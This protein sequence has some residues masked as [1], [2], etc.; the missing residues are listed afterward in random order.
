MRTA[1]PRRDRALPG[2]ADLLETG[3]TLVGHRLDKR[4]VVRTADGYAKVVRPSRA[5]G[6][7]SRHTR[8]AAALA[9]VPGAPHV[10]EL[11]D[12]DEKNGVLV[13]AALAGEPSK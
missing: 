7:A 1:T 5:A 2:L 12:V 3:G 13:F 11:L 10:P 6:F 4:A 9:T 8:V